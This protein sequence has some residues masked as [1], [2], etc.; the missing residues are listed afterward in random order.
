MGWCTSTT[1]IQVSPISDI[2]QHQL[3]HTDRTTE[4]VTPWRHWGDPTDASD[5]FHVPGLSPREAFQPMINNFRS[6]NYL[7]LP[8]SIDHNNAPYAEYGRD[9]PDWI[10]WDRPNYQAGYDVWEATRRLVDIYLDCDWDVNAVEQRAF[11]RE[12]FVARRERHLENVVK[13]L[14]DIANG[15]ESENSKWSRGLRGRTEL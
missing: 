6:L 1:R 10:D 3:H 9:L 4:L 14:E 2:V 15:I 11:R 5:Y 7:G 12:E 8:P 13:P